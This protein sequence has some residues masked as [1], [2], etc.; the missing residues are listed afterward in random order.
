MCNTAL[1]PKQYKQ[2]TYCNKNGR[3]E[4]IIP[5]TFEVNVCT[6][7][8]FSYSSYHCVVMKSVVQ[9]SFG[10]R[11]RDR[12]ASDGKL[13]GQWASVFKVGKHL[14]TDTYNT[15]RLTLA[16]VIQVS[17]LCRI[18]GRNLKDSARRM[19]NR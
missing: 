10:G 12:R 7:L 3:G 11:D 1:K 16:C 18:E 5:C 6:G 8:L 4:F 14:Y 17:K 15:T 19:L 9:D 2:K 13:A